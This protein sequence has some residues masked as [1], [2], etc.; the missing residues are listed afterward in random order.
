MA[1]PKRILTENAV[2]HVTSRGNERQKMVRDDKD[3][4]LFLR[5]LAE[6]VEEHRVLIHAWVLMDNHYHLVLETPEKNLPAFMGHLN[7]VYTQRFNRR[8]HRVGHLY[9]GRYKAIHVDRDVYLKE[10]CRYVVLNPVRAKMVEHP[11]DWSWSSYRATAGIEKA[12]EWLATDWLL[13]QFGRREVQARKSYRSYVL[14]DMEKADSPWGKLKNGLYLGEEE[15][16]VKMEGLVKKNK[17]LDIPRYQKLLVRPSIGDV[18]GRVAERRGVPASSFKRRSRGDEGKDIAIYLLKKEYAYSLREIGR[19]LGVGFSAVGNR[20][21]K[22][23]VR[24]GKDERLKA[25]IFKVKGSLT[26]GAGSSQRDP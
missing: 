21:H 9:Q 14:K 4:W 1:R 17:S 2:Y 22:M 23:K 11:K 3:R 26:S 15:F 5:V 25:E 6:A 24:V 19:E 20:W 8:H 18:L 12:P 13:G 7:G 16:L 10:L